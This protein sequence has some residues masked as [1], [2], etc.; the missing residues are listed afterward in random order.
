VRAIVGV[1]LAIVGCTDDRGP[2]LLSV[3]PAAAGRGAQVQLTGE[4][5]CGE[6]GN[7][8]TAAGEIQ[9]G[10]SPPTVR[11]IVI[12]Y[13]DDLA[14]IEIPTVIDVGPTVIV[15]TVNEHASNTLDFEVLP[16]P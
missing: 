16:S 10:L 11:A 1:V 8:D 14:I 15:V 6:S 13:A 4:H 3:E 2:R 12:D 9:L 7:C 5:L